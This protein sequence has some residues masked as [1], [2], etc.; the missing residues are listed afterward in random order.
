MGEMGWGGYLGDDAVV[1][2]QVSAACLAAVD[3]RAVE[4][5][6]VAVAHLDSD[7]VFTLV[8]VYEG[9]VTLLVKANE[10]DGQRR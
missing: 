3:A 5:D 9:E 10:V 6:V 8:A 4:V 1:G 2:A 7:S